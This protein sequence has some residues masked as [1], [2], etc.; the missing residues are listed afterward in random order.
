MSH[1][2]LLTLSYAFLKS[3]KAQCT[4]FWPLVHF[5]NSMLKQ[6]I[7]L[8]VLL[9]G[10]NPKLLPS[11]RHLPL[12]PCFYYPLP[13]FHSVVR[14]LDPPVI[15]K[16][17]DVFFTVVQRYEHTSPPFI[18]LLFPG[19]GLLKKFTRNSTPLF[20]RAIHAFTGMS[21]GS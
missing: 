14:Q 5:S 13:Q 15:L 20:P 7:A 12:Y 21:S 6:K 4:V 10:R 8:V 19:R 3:I 16:F 1:P 11:D 18:W 9:P 2:I 17:L